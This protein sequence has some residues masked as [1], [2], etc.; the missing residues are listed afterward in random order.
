MEFINSVIT[1][2][3][4]I[5]SF[6]LLRS[7]FSQEIQKQKT[8]IYLNQL[9]EM[10]MTILKMLDSVIFK[11]KSQDALVADI[12][13]LSNRIMAYG[14]ADSIHIATKMFELSYGT[15]NKS[16]TEK[17]IFSITA[18]YVLLFCQ[19]K[20]DLTNI[21]ISPDHYYRTKLNDYT[22]EHRESYRRANDSLVNELQLDKN[23]LF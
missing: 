23:L 20:Y 9:S 10:P 21:W 17:D 7:S 16:E 15:H 1:V 8:D 2:L 11:Q 13:D 22:T 14:T 19:L 6:Y 4:F 18:I 12:R 5:V 3:G